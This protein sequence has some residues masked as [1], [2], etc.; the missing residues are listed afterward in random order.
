M[1]VVGKKERALAY[2]GSIYFCIYGGVVF[3]TGI[4]DVDGEQTKA[5]FFGYCRFRHI[6]IANLKHFYMPIH[7]A[8]KEGNL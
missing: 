7:S 4:S 2:F 1:Q 5:C 3:D 6:N 8:R